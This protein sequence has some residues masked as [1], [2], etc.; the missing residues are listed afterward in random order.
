M[1]ELL[2]KA[3][4]TCEPRGCNGLEGYQ[5]DNTYLYQVCFDKKGKYYRIF[6][7]KELEYYETCGPMIFKKFFKEIK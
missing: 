1:K 7:T 6:P 4:C 2:G 5:L 3:V